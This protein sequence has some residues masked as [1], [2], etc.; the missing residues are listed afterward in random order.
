MNRRKF[1]KQITMGTL[2]AGSLLSAAA[3]APAA[4]GTSLQRRWLPQIGSSQS[5]W[6]ESRPSR[7]WFR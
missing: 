1:A 5:R 3:Q 2:G 7:L 4:K 6:N